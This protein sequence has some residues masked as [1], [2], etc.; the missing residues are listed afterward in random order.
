VKPKIYIETSFI[1]YLVAHPSRDILI[2]AN[3]QVTQEWWQNRRPKFD[4]YISQLVV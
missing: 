3:Q 4:I 2:A 1:S